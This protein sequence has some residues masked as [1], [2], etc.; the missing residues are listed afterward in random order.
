MSNLFLDVKLNHSDSYANSEDRVS[1]R[2][3]EYR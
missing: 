1:K 2:D 3:S